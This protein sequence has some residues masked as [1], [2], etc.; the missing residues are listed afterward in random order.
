MHGGVT[1]LMAKVGMIW[2]FKKK[3]YFCEATFLIT[4]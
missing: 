3:C 2:K 4:Y 1:K